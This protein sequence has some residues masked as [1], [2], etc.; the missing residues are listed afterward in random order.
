MRIGCV[1]DLHFGISA[2]VSRKVEDFID[3]EIA[4][5]ELDLLV[6]AGDLAETEEGDVAIGTHHRTLLLRLRSA[7]KGKIAFCAGNH[8]IWT[9]NPN[10]DSETVYRERLRDLAGET[11]TTYLDAENLLLEDLAVVGCYGH[12]DFSLRVPDLVHAGVAVTDE[13]YRSQTPPGYAAPIWMDGLRITWR[14]DDCAACAAICAQGRERM[15]SALAQSRKILFISHGVPRNEINGHRQSQ[16]PESLF[17]NA[18]SGTTRLE[19]I[20]RLA[21]P[22][23]AQVVAV[24]G[25]THM[26]IPHT[27]LDGIDYRNVGGNYGTP[28]LEL[29]TAFDEDPPACER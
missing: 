9:C 26:Q 16:R 23:G 5:A 6:I 22:V 11:E 15:Q 28:R 24:S 3:R 20:I 7:V 29:I 1:A 2:P 18:F 25:H 14:W 10:I 19:E 21:V 13:H 12:F 4:S 27:R 17:L 8:D